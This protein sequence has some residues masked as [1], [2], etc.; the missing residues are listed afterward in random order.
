MAIEFTEKPNQTKVLNA[1]NNNIVIFKDDTIPSKTSVLA[2]L[3]FTETTT[4]KEVKIE[5]TP[6][7]NIFYFNFKEILSFFSLIYRFEDSVRPSLG[8]VIDETFILNASID[9]TIFF[10]DETDVSEN[11]TYVFVRGVEQINQ[12]SIIE[13]NNFFPL[14]NTNLT[15]FKGYPFD[16]AIQNHSTGELTIRNLDGIFPLKYVKYSIIDRSRIFLSD[17]NQIPYSFNSNV[18][19]ENRVISLFGGFLVDECEN[20]LRDDEILNV[21]YNTIQMFLDIGSGKT[22]VVN[23]N[24]RLIDNC[25]GVYLKWINEYGTWSYWLFSKINKTEMTT[26]TQGFYNV[27]YLDITQTRTV[28]LSTGK[29]AQDVISLN[30]QTL[31]ENEI[32]QVKSIFVSPR[33]ELYNG[34]YGQTNDIPDFN[35]LWQTVQVADGSVLIKQTKRG[36]VNVDFQIKKNRY[37]Q[38]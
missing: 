16:F 21:G 17:G 3:S 19:F 31:T 13:T 24:F 28:E 12:T 18:G 34:V 35:K 26:S 5:I 14:F 33:V 10:N 11:L 23:F 6:I 38:S 7:N 1:F 4:G 2:E 15:L 32:N 29:K 37:T 27:D 36:L 9:F 30:A 8:V 25:D 22:K 20:I